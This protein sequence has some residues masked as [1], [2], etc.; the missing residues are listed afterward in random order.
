MIRKFECKNCG[1]HFE[2]D[3]KQMVTC[4]NYQ[5]DNVEIAGT[6]FISKIGKI[7]LGVV[8]LAIVA[9]IIINLDRK[10]NIL[11]ED[12]SIV[13]IE[14]DTE[15]DP[16]VPFLDIPPTIEVGELVFEGKGYNFKVGVKAPPSQNVYIAILDPFDNTK[17]VAKSDNG[18]FKEVPYSEVDGAIYS[19]ALM[20]ATAD[21]IICCVE[22]PGFIRQAS[23][24]AKMTVAELQK[25]IDNRDET[26]MGVGENDYLAPE[27]KLKFVGLPSDAVNIPTSLYEVF[28]KL[29][30]ETWTQAK[31]TALAY[32]D[33]NRISV[34]TF[35]VKLAM[36]EF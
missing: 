21:T 3:D 27:C 32:D 18:V 33:K 17:V 13:V 14:P 35:S 31:V 30:M 8:L 24:A 28:E 25:M 7:G 20:D 10:V 34:I 11:H 9:I 2:A 1:K 19:I 16:I 12:K 15:N 36:D 23:V 26:L 22:K 29:D 4:P 6:K 5:N